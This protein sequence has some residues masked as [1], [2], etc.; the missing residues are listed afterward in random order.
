[1]KAYNYKLLLVFFMLWLP[2]QGAAGAVLSVCV[3][4]KNFHIQADASAITIDS[5]HHEDCHKQ[6]ADD[7]INHVLTSLPCDDTSCN[8]YSSTPILS[9]YAVPMLI[10]I[11]ST[12]ISLNSGFTSFDPEQPQRPPLTDLL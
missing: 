6:A 2:L 8:A 12:V 5:H 4:E 7:T 9:D 3:Q 10:E 1:M 11:T